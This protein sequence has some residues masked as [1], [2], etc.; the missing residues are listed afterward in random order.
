MNVQH[1]L[2]DLLLQWGDGLLATQIHQS[3]SKRLNGAFLCPACTVVHGRSFDAMYA[4]LLLSEMKGDSRYRQAAVDLFVWADHTLTLANGAFLNDVDSQWL[5]TTVFAVI[6]LADCLIDFSDLLGEELAGTIK[7]RLKQAAEFIYHFEGLVHNNINYPL[8]NAL[9]LQLCSSI[10]DEPRY[11]DRAAEM[12]AIL[13]TVLTENHLLLGEGVPRTKISNRG[14]RSVDI[15]YNVEE[16][17]PNILRYAQLVED[18]EV[19]S[20]ILNSIRSHLWFF[21]EDGGWDNSF[22]TRNFKWTYWGSRT[23][24]GCLPMLLALAKEDSRYSALVRSHVQLLKEATVDNLLHGGPHYHHAG[25]EACVHH[26]F[27]HITMVA[28]VLKGAHLEQINWDEGTVEV[29]P[30]ISTLG[31]KAFNEIDTWV[32]VKPTYSATVTA[33]DW[34]YMIGGHVSGGTL[35]LL[36]SRKAGPILVASMGEYTLRERKNQQVPVNVIHECLALRIEETWE[37]RTYSSIFDT[38]AEV[39]WSDDGEVCTVRGVLKNNAEE[40]PETGS[41]PYTLEYRFLDDQ[42]AIRFSSNVGKLIVP[43]ISRSDEMV[44]RSDNQV[45]IIKEDAVVVVE[46]EQGFGLPYGEERIFHLSPGLQ[47]L[48][49]DYACTTEMQQIDLSWN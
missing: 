9:A 30:R 28:K 25:Q 2:Q 15:G 35:S 7:T 3:T 17:L 1:E 38:S 24:D 42:I 43:L 12:A 21:L 34:P 13:P 40:E 27:E 22:G 46:S 19:V 14:C 47:A 36:H 16:T 18:Q 32:Q 11:A 41:F 20:Q 31:V 4:L 39:R 48:R 37:D 44:E 8:S 33:Y 6:N 10:F 5:G 49:L 45:R 29:L 26:S 23:S